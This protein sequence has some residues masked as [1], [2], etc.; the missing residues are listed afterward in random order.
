MH[1]NRPRQA[2]R[3]L[4]QMSAEPAPRVASCATSHGP[5]TDGG[6]PVRDRGRDDRAGP[7]RA[8]RPRR[9][10]GDR[11]SRRPPRPPDGRAP[12]PGRLAEA[13]A[14]AL[15]GYERA[16]RGGPP[17]G[18]DW[19]GLGLGKA[20]LLGGQPCTAARWLSECVE[21]SATTGFD[22]PRRLEL[23]YLAM[24][25]AW[26]GEL[27]DARRC[28]AE[29]APPVGVPRPW[30]STSGRHGTQA[31][32]GELSAAR[33]TLLATADGAEAAGSGRPRRGCCSTSPASAA[34]TSS[35]A[36][37]AALARHCEG[38]ASMRTPPARGRSPSAT[39]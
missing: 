39:A 34:P 14:I 4:E 32:A 19:F 38:L 16:A 5:G 13:S 15:I 12:G 24:A 25:L 30:S 22:G 11:P 35:P 20:A 28:V 29:Q 36:R 26:V 10:D 21:L 33:R 37:L 9:P 6:R 23:S 27:D 2:L 31:A 7:C 8:P 3:R 17:L 18:R 1:S